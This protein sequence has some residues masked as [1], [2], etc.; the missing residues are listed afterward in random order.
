M[1]ETRN[2]GTMAKNDKKHQDK[3]IVLN[4]WKSVFKIVVKQ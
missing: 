3:V 4:S 2:Y 1:K